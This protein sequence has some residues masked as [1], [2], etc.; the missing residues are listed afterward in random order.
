LGISAGIILLVL[1]L[2]WIICFFARLFDPI[3]IGAN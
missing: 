1:T 2:V 3:K